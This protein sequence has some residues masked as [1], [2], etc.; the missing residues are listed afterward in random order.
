MDHGILLVKFWLHVSKDEQLRRFEERQRTP[1]K[2]WKLT[3]EDWRNRERWERV[4]AWR[5]TRWWR[6]PARGARRGCWWRA[7]DKLFARI[8]VI[9]TLADRLER[10]AQEA[11]RGAEAVI[12][13]A[14]GES[15]HT[16]TAGPQ[17]SRR[18]RAGSGKYAVCAA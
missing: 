7:N 12:A 14:A 15:G 6:A 9:R 3:D 8:K 17:R 18:A 1:H 10:D 16:G 13:S 2:A 5:S 4:R 11:S